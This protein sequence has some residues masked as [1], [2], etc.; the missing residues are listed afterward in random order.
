MP[1]HVRGAY[2]S[3]LCFHVTYSVLCGEEE[4]AANYKQ[5]GH[6][7]SLG[8]SSSLH[9]A[10][11]VSDGLGGGSGAQPCSI[12][13]PLAEGSRGP[14]RHRRWAEAWR[15]AGG[16]APRHVGRPAALR[17]ASCKADWTVSCFAA[18]PG[19]DGSLVSLLP[20]TLGREM[21]FTWAA[22]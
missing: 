6:L 1:N 15:C 11:C 3:T 18:A 9:G 16:L 12:S 21:C 13:E 7:L 19:G 8:Q 20:S 5:T 17:P 22:R 4:H 2:L 14:R 10:G